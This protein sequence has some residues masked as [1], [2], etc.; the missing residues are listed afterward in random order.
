M[1]DSIIPGVIASAIFAGIVAVIKY[2]LY[3]AYVASIY[4]GTKIYGEWDVFYEGTTE[5]SAVISFKQVGTSIEGSSVVS[6]NKAGEVVDRKYQYKGTFLNRS[7]VLTFEDKKNPLMMG[8][9]MVFHHIDSDAKK[10]NGIAV[11][12]KPETNQVETSNAQ[13]VQKNS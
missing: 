1:I 5:A 9:A 6:K 2:W 3:P 11:Y 7:I 13:L 8:G 4:K 10:M 12:F